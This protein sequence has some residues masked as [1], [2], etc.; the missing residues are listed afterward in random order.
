MI[1]GV[2]TTSSDS[3]KLFNIE[4]ENLNTY[5][6]ISDDANTANITLMF[7]LWLGNVPKNTKT[8]LL[9]VI[10]PENVSKF[11]SVLPKDVKRTFAPI[12]TSLQQE[13]LSQIGQIE[14]NDK[15]LVANQLTSFAV[16]YEIP[17][18]SKSLDLSLHSPSIISDRLRALT[19]HQQL[20]SIASANIWLIYNNQT[21]RIVA[22]KPASENRLSGN[23]IVS[24]TPV[25]QS[26]W[27]QPKKEY[28]R[29]LWYISRASLN[30][31][32]YLK[33]F[34]MGDESTLSELRA[35]LDSLNLSLKEIQNTITQHQQALDTFNNK[36]NFL[37][38]RQQEIELYL[39]KLNKK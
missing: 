28:I 19:P 37:L 34:I 8:L 6:L 22:D 31:P 26:K 30:Y 20:I 3:M 24:S 38:D 7:D 15:N 16:T 2:L 11:N 35:I 25:L 1:I 4:L 5:V 23:D 33:A 32:F 17:L 21:V 13:K 27:V 9:N 39:D 18:D 36:L 12:K 10:L 29:L 14:L